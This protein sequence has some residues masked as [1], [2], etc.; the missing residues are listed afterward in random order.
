MR[1]RQLLV[2]ISIHNTADTDFDT[3][4]LRLMV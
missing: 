2:T 1:M 4:G 3:K